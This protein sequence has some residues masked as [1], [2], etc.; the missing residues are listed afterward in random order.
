MTRQ[1]KSRVKELIGFLS[2]VRGD[3]ANIA[4]PPSQLAPRSVVEVP[5]CW[6]ERPSVFAAPALES[7]PEK[8]ALLVLKW[9]LSSLRTHF[10]I[11]GDTSLALKKPLNSFLGELF[12]GEYTDDGA[13]TK[14]V[15]EQV[16]HHP[17]ITAC[18]I[19]DDEHGI[20][21]EGYSRVEMTFDGNLNIKQ[22]GHA[23][24]HINEFDEDYLIPFPNI[25][26]K[27]FLSGHL[28]PEIV[29]KYAIVSSSG[30][31]SEVSFSG[32]G[33]FSGVKNAFR[34]VTY[35]KSDR[36]KTPIYTVEGQWSDKFDVI[37]SGTVLETID[38]AAPPPTVIYPDIKDN[39]ETRSA[40]KSTIE[41]LKGGNTKIAGV[42]KSKLEEAQRALRRKEAVQEK[43]WKPIFFSTKDQNEGQ[44]S[45]KNLA[46]ETSWQLHYEKTK[47]IWSFDAE[48]AKR[49]AT[50]FHQSITPYG[51]V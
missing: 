50:P 22:F 30:Y 44:S 28:Y 37:H 34:A 51:S 15:T 1:E 47:G 23:T 7:N 12:I 5:S 6:S 8:R 18:H 39:W 17:P 46:R 36:A 32:K 48:K 29:G 41:A 45:F 11:G 14:L 27:G 42:E 20:S 3:L 10:Y 16:S 40:W 33:Y 13:T 19:S 31:V 38:T 4:S 49:A 26:V 35:Q 25:R 9:F 2:T 24:I 21:A 43:E